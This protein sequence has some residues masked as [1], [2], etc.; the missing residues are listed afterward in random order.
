MRSFS[1]DICPKTF[2]DAKALAKHE[3][4]HYDKKGKNQFFVP[5]IVVSS[6]KIVFFHFFVIVD[7]LCNYCD[8][9]YRHRGDLNKHLRTHLGDLMYACDQCPMRFRLPRELQMHTYDHYNTQED[10]R[11]TN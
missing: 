5:M 2:Y 3:L 10:Q 7:H 8:K 1:C 6:N 9:S 11:D 4:T